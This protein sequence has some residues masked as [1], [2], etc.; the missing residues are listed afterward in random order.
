MSPSENT[1]IFIV[2]DHPIVR[3]GLVQV[4]SLES[5]LIVIGEASNA[6]EAIHGIAETH[7]TLAIVDISLAGSSGIELTK[8]I[9]DKH[10]TTL[11]MIIS[12]YDE[13]IYLERA[14]RA[15]A[16]GYITKL[17]ASNH[18]ITAIRKI[19]GGDVYMSENWKN[20]LANQFAN[21]SRPIDQLDPSLRILS[22][23]ES[24]VLQLT[25]QGYSTRRIAAELFISVKTVE[26]HYANIK[27]KL[28]LKNSHELIRYAVKW[29][30][31]EKHFKT[32]NNTLENQA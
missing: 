15:G 27:S 12:M 8:Q 31:T 32:N 7:P 24:D 21:Q 5:D 14:F 19:I 16:R 11:V 4:I 20:M 22:D 17:E 1:R 9:L 3:S 10:P 26:S 30:L 13:S 6:K 28:G 23:R 29:T 2:D 18:I 25:G